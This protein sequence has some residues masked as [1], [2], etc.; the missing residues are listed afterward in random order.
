MIRAGTAC[1]KVG[2]R[3]R[4]S[5]ISVRKHGDADH[6]AV[7]LSSLPLA[8]PSQS[9][10]KTCPLLATCSA[11]PARAALYRAHVRIA[12]VFTTPL[13]SAALRAM[14]TDRHDC[15]DT[16]GTRSP[17]CKLPRHGRTSSDETLGHLLLLLSSHLVQAAQGT[18]ETLALRV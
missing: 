1:D 16:T 2:G 17:R 14:Q 13:P 18:Q 8:T 11:V 5:T 10:S 6:S 7:D 9:H 15:G 3:Q 12:R 4:P